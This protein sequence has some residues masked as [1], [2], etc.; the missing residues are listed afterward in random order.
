M[1][2]QSKKFLNSIKPIE[3]FSASNLPPEPSYSD[4]YSW[5]AHP[6]VDGYH[7][8]VPK[9]ENSIL[10]SLKDID[11]FFIHPTGFFGK[12]WNGPVDRNHA[13]FKD[14][15]FIWLLKLLVL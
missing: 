7:Q 6:E 4:L 13:S 12:N 1:N 9:G 15:R 11:V 3:P 5:V 14:L 2:D 10:K 8:I